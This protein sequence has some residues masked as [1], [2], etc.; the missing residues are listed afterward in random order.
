VG[1][2]EAAGIDTLL[3]K[4]PAIAA[5]LY[6][7]GEPRLYTDAD[8]LVNPRRI[9]DAERVLTGLGYALRDPEGERDALVSGPHAQTWTRPRDAAV[10]DLHHA[11][12][13]EILAA[14]V[15]WPEL[16]GRADRLAVAGA[17]VAVLDRP[18]LAL[19]VAVHAAHHGPDHDGPLEDLRRA[20]ATGSD[21]LWSEALLVAERLMAVPQFAAG[22]R[23]L[24][25]GAA[26]AQRL[27]LPDQRT[28]DAL[29]Q[30]QV[31]FGFAR[32]A[33][34]RGLRA[35]LALIVRELFPAPSFM[36]WWRPWSRG[37]RARLA[38]A[39]AYRLGW[40]M[41]TAVPGLLAWRRARG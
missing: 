22:L 27:G 5:W 37:S 16:Q 39:Y 17:A 8:L 18:S 30:D 13:G 41:T 14:D 24:G 38:A 31:A 1:A 7:P 21:A 6:A 34:T 32:L 15:L 28:L 25:N 3:L 40:L 2:L 10:I 23:L 29:A 20:L 36:H 26:L 19:L 33:A 9:L 4:G 35:K 12:P 11:L